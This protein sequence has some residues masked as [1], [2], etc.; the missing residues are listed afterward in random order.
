MSSVV[1]AATIYAYII[2]EYYLGGENTNKNTN[3]WS[4][5]EN[6]KHKT[7]VINIWLN[8][9]II[10]LT[11][12]ALLSVLQRLHIFHAPSTNPSIILFSS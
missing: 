10:N 7:Y 12:C 3:K 6:P 5:K 4:S 9:Y 1:G 8:I 2:K 11:L